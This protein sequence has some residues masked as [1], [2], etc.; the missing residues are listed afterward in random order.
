MFKRLCLLLALFILLI[1]LTSCNSGKGDSQT[2]DV[3]ASGTAQDQSSQSTADT[4]D[5]GTP[6]SS[7]ESDDAETTSPDGDF[8]LPAEGVRPVAVM[9]DNEGT[10]SLPQGGLNKA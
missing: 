7:S 1:P 4:S 3:Q 6:S 5:S 2:A 10:R 8:V 9:I